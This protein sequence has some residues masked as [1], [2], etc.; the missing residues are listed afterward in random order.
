MAITTVRLPPETERD[1]EELAGRLDR[2]KGWVIN[3]A[4]TE[5]VARQRLEQSR[6][7][8]TLE[9]LDAAAEG[10]VVDAER[11]HAWLRSW[12]TA[13]EPPPPDRDG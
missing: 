10:R 3:Q 9:A 5:Y 4:L 2:S 12:G 11:V 7:Q 1:L 6:W 13:D 8:E